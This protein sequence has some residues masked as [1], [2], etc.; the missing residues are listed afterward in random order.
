MK[1]GEA[2]APLFGIEAL[3]VPR[4][5]VV[6]DIWAALAGYEFC[7]LLSCKPHAARQ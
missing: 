5:L 2:G 7:W 3:Y 4:G 1:C 6:S